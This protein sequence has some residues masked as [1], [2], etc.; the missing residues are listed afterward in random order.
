MISSTNS[1][2]KFCRHC[3]RIV[4]VA[5]NILSLKYELAGRPNKDVATA[6]NFE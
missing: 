4:P 1:S 6:L 3:S 5:L 2:S